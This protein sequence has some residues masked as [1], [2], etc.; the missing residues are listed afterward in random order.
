MAINVV[1]YLEITAKSKVCVFS[2]WL[3]TVSA[4]TGCILSV[5]SEHAVSSLMRLCFAQKHFTETVVRGQ[6]A[7][8]LIRPPAQQLE[9]LCKS[10]NISKLTF[11][12]ANEKKKVAR[13]LTSAKRGPDDPADR[14]H[15]ILHVILGAG[16][17]KVGLM[18]GCHPLSVSPCSNK[19]DRN[20]DDSN[21]L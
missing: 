15:P 2:A 9:A 16:H 14:L 13:I 17:K 1:L 3:N 6:L 10:H 7:H 20:T 4:Q 19:R 11:Y 21:I 8:T 18:V 12:S 5:G